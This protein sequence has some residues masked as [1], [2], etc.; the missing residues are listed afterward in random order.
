MSGCAATHSDA[1][2]AKLL[3]HRGR[4]EAQLGT[5]LAQTPT[6]ALQVGCTLDI[7][8]ATVAGD[9]PEGGDTKEF[10]HHGRHPRAGC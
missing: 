3:A 1:G 8:R 7:H 2:A 4:R 6:L 10:G 9:Q 5:D